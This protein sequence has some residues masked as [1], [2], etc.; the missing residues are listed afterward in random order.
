ME[1]KLSTVTYLTDTKSNRHL[2]LDGSYETVYN[3]FEFVLSED[4][5]DES[6]FEFLTVSALHMDN[7]DKEL[8]ADNGFTATTIRVAHS[9]IDSSVFRQ[10][11]V[12]SKSHSGF[13]NEL[14]SEC[15]AYGITTGCEDLHA[16]LTVLKDLGCDL[17]KFT[18]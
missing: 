14:A 13:Y 15:E 18:D 11:H 12:M 9:A 3:W 6:L 16:T 7:G 5:F 4:E 17:K 2:I 10:H 8:L 1:K